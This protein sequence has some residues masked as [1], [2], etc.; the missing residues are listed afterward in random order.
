MYRLDVLVTGVPGKTATHGGL[1]WSTLALLRDETK[2]VLVDT[3]PPQYVQLIH[4]RLPALGV[5]PED[6]THVLATHLHWDHVS[7]F[8]MFPE[9]RVV[10]GRQEF[11]WASVQPPGT[12]LVPDV[13]VARLASTM[14]NVQLVEEGEEALEDVVCLV[15]PGHS[16][17]HV[18]YK[19][20]T[21]VGEIL[22]AGDSCKNRFELATSTV[23]YTLDAAASAASVDRLRELMLRDPSLVMLPGHDVRLALVDGE[24]TALDPQTVQFSMVYDTVNGSVNTPWAPEPAVAR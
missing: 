18:T 11:E 4:D 17:G 8:T 13:H 6:V 1:G 2:V 7:N 9:A 24:V 12:F 23:D 21:D 3:G 10:V 15:T 16:P 22:F 5:K 20:K 19:V 14:E